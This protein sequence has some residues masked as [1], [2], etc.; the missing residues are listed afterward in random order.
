[1][2][3]GFRQITFLF[4]LVFLIGCQGFPQQKTGVTVLGQVGEKAVSPKP[5]SGALVQIGNK[6]AK[7]NNKGRYK[8]TN[9]KPGKVELKITAPGH[10][11]YKKEVEIIEGDNQADVN[12]LLT[13]D[14][15]MRRWLTAQ[16]DGK[17]A[18]AY[19]YLHPEAR[20]KV[21]KEDYISYFKSLRESGIRIKSI[22]VGKP[23]YLKSWGSAA[24]KRI[25]KNV[26]EMET[27]VSVLI[28]KSGK[29]KT[30]TSKATTH[31]VK[32]YGQWKGFWRMPK[33][34]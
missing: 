16:K 29:T 26:A 21:S 24:T 27:S 22:F 10:E 11:L 19:E 17:Y 28:K 15:T 18:E 23:K 6:R 14:E 2:I 5:A 3:R 1:M 4:L 7:T 34:K 30:V 13:P 32:V 8:I 20:A 33:R 12:L 9:L 31:M 25:Y